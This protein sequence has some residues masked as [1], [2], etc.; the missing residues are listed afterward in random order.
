MK[1]VSHIAVATALPA[2]S[3]HFASTTT[4]M[5]RQ[6]WLFVAILAFA[7]LS[8]AFSLDDLHIDGIEEYLHHG[9]KRQASGTANTPTPPASSTLRP[10]SSQPPVSTPAP[11]SQPPVS[12]PPQSN[13]PQSTPAP[14]SNNPASSP[15]SSAPPVSSRA[16]SA[17]RTTANIYTSALVS[18][19]LQE[20]VTIFTTISDGQDLLITSTGTRSIALTTGQAVVTDPPTSQSDGSNSGGGLSQNN[21]NIIGGVVGGVGGALLLGGIAL[22]FL[23]MRK[24][25]T[26][27]H[28]DDDDMTLGTGSALGDK[29]TSGHGPTPFQSNL[30]QYHNPGGRPNAAANF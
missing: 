18:T 17:P 30:E 27:V 26:R 3:A 11:S 6:L 16:S 9:V 14:S 10:P 1:R 7:A 22:V 29:P 12:N 4:N 5:L 2:P 21:K 24:R 8:S 23:R 15:R 19:S 25:R 13:P 20:F 28:E